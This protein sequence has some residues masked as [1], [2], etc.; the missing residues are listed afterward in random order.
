MSE[1]V[2][3]HSV[4]GLR[5]SV[6]SAAD[7]LRRAGHVVHLP[8]LYDGEVFD[9][10]DRAQ[11]HVDS[12][13]GYPAL[14]R[15][16]TESVA[17]LGPDLVYG[18][19]SNGGGCAEYLVATRPGARAALLLHSSLPLSAFQ[20]DLSWPGSVPVQV[21]YARNDPFRQASHVRAFAEEV[22]ASGAG[23][24]YYEYPVAG[25]LF[26]DSD[27]PGEYDE[28]ATDLVFGRVLDFLARLDAAG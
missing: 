23:Y 27:L 5:P 9:R 24:E 2:L 4:L 28:D 16:T 10:Y 13:G 17:D 26:T 19:F 1:I 12:L 21:H 25:H 3:F 6:R 14:L 11:Q 7:R 18:G 20:L 8:D 22:T 15:R